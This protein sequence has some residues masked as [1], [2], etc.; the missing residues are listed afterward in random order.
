MFHFWR[1]WV[2]VSRVLFSAA[3][4]S[5]AILQLWTRSGGRF[6]CCKAQTR[7][8]GHEL[9][10]TGSVVA[11]TAPAAPTARGVFPG[12]GI[13][14][15]PPAWQVGLPLSRQGIPTSDVISCPA[16]HCNRLACCLSLCAPGFQ[17]SC[18]KAFARLFSPLRQSLLWPYLTVCPGAGL[19][20]L[21]CL[22]HFIYLFKAFNKIC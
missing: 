19:S 22:L 14:P 15:M 4:G 18:L 20:Q 7:A 1:C 2:S 21:S 8:R 10:G 11:D 6:S 16:S 17:C 9:C 12:S 13:K 3:V 5:G